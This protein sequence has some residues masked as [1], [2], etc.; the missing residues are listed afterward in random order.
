MGRNRGARRRSGEC[1]QFRNVQGWRLHLDRKGLD[2]LSEVRHVVRLLNPSGANLID[3]QGDDTEMRGN[4]RYAKL[5]MS[6]QK[7]WKLN[8]HGNECLGD[9]TFVFHKHEDHLGLEKWLIFS[10][11]TS[12]IECDKN[13]RTLG[14]IAQFVFREFNFLCSLPIVLSD[15][16]AFRALQ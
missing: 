8:S 11:G 7:P 6:N 10:D 4:S 5:G 9:T 16:S 13:F 1:F 2:V 15:T 14:E 3:M 12:R